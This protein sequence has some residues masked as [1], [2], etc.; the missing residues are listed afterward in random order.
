MAGW[1]RRIPWRYVILLLALCGVI[2]STYL[3]AQAGRHAAW[4]SQ[5][6]NN[7]RQIGLAL[8][9]YN[10]TFRCLPSTGD[11]SI[12]PL[13]YSRPSF[14]PQQHGPATSCVALPN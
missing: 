9:S 7:L 12:M 11:G 3:A 6:G 8:H 10:D 13:L 4:R 1:V 5:R 14:D 2:A